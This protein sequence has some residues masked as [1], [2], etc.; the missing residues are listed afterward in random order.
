MG[1]VA[2]GGRQ[3]SDR[4]ASARISYAVGSGE[5]L[6]PLGKGSNK[7]PPGVWGGREMGWKGLGL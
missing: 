7:S 2:A 1:G 6:R 5:I 4:G 3:G